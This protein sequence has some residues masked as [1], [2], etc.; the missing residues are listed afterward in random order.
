MRRR[1][2]L[3]GLLL[4]A[5][6]D[7]QD[8]TP[9]PPWMQDAGPTRTGTEA[10]PTPPAAQPR[11]QAPLLLR[12][13]VSPPGPVWVGQR[14][15]VTV[16]AM[17]PVRFVEP[18]PWPD[19]TAAQGRIIALPEVQTVPGTERIDGQ[20]YAAI[21][22]S[23][24]IFPAETG[25]LV[26]APLSMAV[27]VG[28]PDGQPVEAEATANPAPL[29]VRI[30]PN[31]PD[32]RRL[33][34]APSFRMAAATEGSVTQI[35]VGQAVVRTLRME[36]DDTGSMLL[37][38]AIWGQ[39]EGVRVYPDPPVLQDRSD[40]GV[41]HALRS[42]RAAFVPQRPGPLVLPGFAVSWFDPRSGRTRQVAVDPM[43]LDVV[44]ATATDG[45]P[46]HP[47]LAWRRI[48]AGMLLLAFLVAGTFGLW[49]RLT[50]RVASPL[51]DLARACGRGDA[52]GALRALYRWADSHHQRGGEQTIAALA[53][54]ADVPDL[55]REAAGLE[56]HFL[57]T[58]E[59]P[60]WQGAALL[61]A[62]RRVEHARH[63]RRIADASR[64]LPPLNPALRFGA[65]P[66]LR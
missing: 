48:A 64:D 32:V 62:A 57:S 41:L 25:S 12:V 3:V 29:E 50:H 1:L 63:T 28:G 18:P 7:A 23:Y 19:L 58:G 53:A 10:A 54:R 6:A 26:L 22:R 15:I 2:I 34:V 61:R 33:I 40:R 5:P 59:A 42:E 35:Q 49:W 21:E 65:P 46:V 31:V 30:P 45:A 24:S 66:R 52:R 17:T 51:R 38:P 14:V 55:A 20:S 47:V 44:P 27:R 11:Q 8:R 56:R 9:A 36:A 4:A 37:P 60:D 16:T 43:H 13:S 39:P